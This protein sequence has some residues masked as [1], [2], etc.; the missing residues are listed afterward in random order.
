MLLLLL[1]GFFFSAKLTVNQQ[2]Y[3][4]LGNWA[5]FE[6]TDEEIKHF[7]FIFSSSLLYNGNIPNAFENL[8][9]IV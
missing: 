3:L 8:S 1:Q 7:L 2:I 6:G 9:H 4:A 5:K